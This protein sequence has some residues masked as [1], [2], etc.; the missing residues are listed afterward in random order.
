MIEKHPKENR[1]LLEIKLK[2][3]Y[4]QDVHATKNHLVT[5]ASQ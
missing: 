3:N 4:E 2:I 1:K 5:S